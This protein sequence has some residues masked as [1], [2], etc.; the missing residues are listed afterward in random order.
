MT[1]DHA[2]CKMIFSLVHIFVQQLASEPHKHNIFN[3]ADRDL[4]LKNNFFRHLTGHN[5]FLCLSMLRL[6]IESQHHRSSWD[7]NAAQSGVL[8]IGQIFKAQ[9][10]VIFSAFVSRDFINSTTKRQ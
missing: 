9:T 2:A 10:L 8:G 1:K 6:S 3:H 5:L 4:F 7:N